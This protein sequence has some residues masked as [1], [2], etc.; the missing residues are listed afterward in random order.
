MRRALSQTLV[1]IP[2]DPLSLR[3]MGMKPA[4]FDYQ[5]PAT[6]REAIGLLGSHLEAA[7]IAAGLNRSGKPGAVQSGRPF[8][9]PMETAPRT[10]RPVADQLRTHGPTLATPRDDSGDDILASI[11]FPARQQTTG[12][13][14]YP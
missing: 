9:S 10:G 4:P 1:Q 5:A 6:L 14:T 11:A 13:A 7:V 2:S 8:Y 3:G 12:H